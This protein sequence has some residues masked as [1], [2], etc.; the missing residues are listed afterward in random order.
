[1]NELTKARRTVCAGDPPRTP[2]YLHESVHAAYKRMQER[3]P[4]AY[5]VPFKLRRKQKEAKP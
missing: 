5:A 1:M 4:D 3:R 2:K